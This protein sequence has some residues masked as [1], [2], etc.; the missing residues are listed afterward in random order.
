MDFS[1][2]LLR[3]GDIRSLGTAVKSYLT[4]VLPDVQGG[5]LFYYDDESNQVYTADKLGEHVCLPSPEYIK[6]V[7]RT[8][9]VVLINEGQI[10]ECIVPHLPEQCDNKSSQVGYYPVCSEED[11]HVIAVLVVV[12]RCDDETVINCIQ[13]VIQQMMSLTF[14]SLNCLIENAVLAF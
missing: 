5:A 14:I 4:N 2:S 11:G 13:K 9:E 3:C 7:Y 8:K 1:L 10:P 6:N 12:G